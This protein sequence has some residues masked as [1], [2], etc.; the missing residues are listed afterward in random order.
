MRTFVF[1]LWFFEFT[2]TINKIGGFQTECKH[3]HTQIQIQTLLYATWHKRNNTI[4]QDNHNKH[5]GC[6]NGILDHSHTY[7]LAL[8]CWCACIWY[9]SRGHWT[10]YSASELFSKDLTYKWHCISYIQFDLRVNFVRFKI[11]SRIFFRVF[12]VFFFR[13]L[14]N[15]LHWDWNWI[16]IPIFI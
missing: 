10:T 9:V 2:N 15:Y 5:F 6:V 12:L 1:A 4:I 13:S 7:S 14:K 3:T 16:K 8:T 11:E